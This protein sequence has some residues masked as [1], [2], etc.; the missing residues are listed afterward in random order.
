MV[1]IASMI[2]VFVALAAAA[3]QPQDPKSVA[4]SLGSA[5]KRGPLKLSPLG[6]GCPIR[7]FTT[8]HPLK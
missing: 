5:L 6:S 4:T 1:P 3:E 7:S 2:L 8:N